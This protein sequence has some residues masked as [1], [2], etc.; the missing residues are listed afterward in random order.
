MF[1]F[2][3]VRFI[4]KVSVR[5][6]TVFLHS[7]LKHGLLYFVEVE[8]LDICSSTMFNCVFVKYKM[9]SSLFLLASG[10]SKPKH[11]V[12]NPSQLDFPRFQPGVLLL[13]SSVLSSNRISKC[14]LPQVLSCTFQL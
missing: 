12:S 4:L 10:V 1:K 3:C 14:S 13:N 7:S 9:F 6:L 5:N 11:E 8:L 2:S